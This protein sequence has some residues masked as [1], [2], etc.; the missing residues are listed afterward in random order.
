MDKQIEKYLRKLTYYYNENG[1]LMQYPSRRPMRVMALSRIMD[2]FE[3]SK[4]YSEKQVNEIIKESICFDDIELVRRELFQYRMLGR[5]RD[6][7]KYWVEPEWRT[8]SSLS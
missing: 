4:E 5:M 8:D 2:K 6:G 3:M 1:L 7:S